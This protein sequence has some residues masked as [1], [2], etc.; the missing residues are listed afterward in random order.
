MTRQHVS[1]ILNNPDSNNDITII[2]VQS[3]LF[4]VTVHLQK[5]NTSL[6]WNSRLYI[7]FCCSVLF[8]FV[9]FNVYMYVNA[10]NTHHI[11]HLFKFELAVYSQSL[12]N[13]NHQP[14][15]RCYYA[16]VQFVGY[17]LLK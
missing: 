8:N 7:H 15:E 17:Y 4:C 16:F 11:V 2:I 9:H 1:Q 5:A 10:V 13:C 12:L 6:I 14:V 3:V